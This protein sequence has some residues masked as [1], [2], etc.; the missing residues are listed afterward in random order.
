MQV[1]KWGVNRGSG[2]IIKRFIGLGGKIYVNQR[3]KVVWDS[4]TYQGSMMHCS[5]NKLGTSY[6][7]N[8]HFFTGFLKQNFSHSVQ[9]WKPHVQV[10]HPMHARALLGGKD[11]IKRGEIWRIGDGKSVN[12]WKV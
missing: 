2:E 3:R 7:I 11:V 6:M 12:I 9:S 1:A 4:R 8:L 10:W 5:P